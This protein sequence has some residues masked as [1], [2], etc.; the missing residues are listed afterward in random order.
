M[1]GSAPPHAPEVATGLRVKQPRC[2]AKASTSSFHCS[3]RKR[4][5][6]LIFPKKRTRSPTLAWSS[7]SSPF[8]TE[9]LQRL[10]NSSVAFSKSFIAKNLR[11]KKYRSSL[12]CWHRSLIAIHRIASHT[13][14]LHP[15]AGLRGHLSGTRPSSSRYPRAGRVGSPV[16]ACYLNIRSSNRKGFGSAKTIFFASGC[17]GFTSAFQS[18]STAADGTSNTNDRW[19]SAHSEPMDINSGCLSRRRSCG[20]RLVS[21]RSHSASFNGNCASMETR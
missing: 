7:A 17:S 21:I 13:G 12:P 19:E 4:M 3:H 14:R 16:H 2:A 10:L 15:R 5:R 18:P 11:E 8:P 6:S 1:V 9:I 20:S